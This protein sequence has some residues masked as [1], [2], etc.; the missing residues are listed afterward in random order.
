MNDTRDDDARVLGVAVPGHA[1][2]A[3]TCPV[4]E[5][6]H[7]ALE[8]FLLCRTQWRVLVGMGGVSYQGLDYPA[9]ESVMRMQGI[10]DAGEIL[11]QLQHLEAGALEAL[12]AR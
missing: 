1:D 6:H 8:V 11:S 9:V 10:D 5:E 2:E 12:N 3:P 4:W 7:P